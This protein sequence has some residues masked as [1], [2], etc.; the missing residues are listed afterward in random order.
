MKLFSEEEYEWLGGFQCY[1][2]ILQKYLSKH[3][4]SDSILQLGKLNKAFKGRVIYSDTLC[5]VPLNTSP[6]INNRILV[7]S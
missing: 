3:Q 2:S 4:Q 7:Y 5:K 6:D 1:K